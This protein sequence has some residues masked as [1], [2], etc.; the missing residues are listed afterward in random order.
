MQFS[1]SEMRAESLNQPRLALTL[2]RATSQGGQ[3][4]SKHEKEGSLQKE[5]RPADTVIWGQRDPSG[6][7]DPQNYSNKYVFL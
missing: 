5:Q 4:A 3:A 7:W 1:V 6:N 2:R